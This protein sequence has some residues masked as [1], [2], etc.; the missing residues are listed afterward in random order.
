MSAVR[1][2]EGPIT[3]SLA[4]CL[5]VSSCCRGRKGRREGGEKGEIS[6]RAHLPYPYSRNQ[7]PILTQNKNTDSTIAISSSSTVLFT[8]LS[9]AEF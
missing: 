3:A 9:R 4:G 7:M 6:C 2:P 5:E 8:L 1:Y